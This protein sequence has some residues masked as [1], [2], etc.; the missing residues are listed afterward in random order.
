MNRGLIGSLAVLVLAT[1]CAS[2]AAARP[3]APTLPKAAE[4][5]HSP[6][7]T[8]TPAGTLVPVGQG[9]EGVVADPVTHLVAVGTR[10]PNALVLLDDRTGQVAMR[11][12][13]PGHLRHLQLAAP[14]GPVLVPDES[15]NSL[16]TVSLPTGVVQA[17]VHTGSSPHDATAA[18]NGTVFVANEAGSSVVAV[19]NKAVVHTFT[20]VVQ[21]AGL[22]AV[23]TLV[24]LVDVRQNALHIYDANTLTSRATLP[25]GAGPT[26]VEA[27]KRG[28]L[29]VIDTRGN[30]VL[31]Y[32]LTPSP[33]QL[34]R[35]AL[36]GTPYGV[37][38]DPVRD[39]LWVTLTALN[40]VVGIDVSGA[41]PRVVTTI[42]TVRQPN[43]VSVD[44]STGELFVTGTDTGVLELI[45]P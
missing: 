37:T 9:A 41:S 43:T 34:D 45:N 16:L 22:A 6:M 1:G 4:P 25:A 31:R 27:D 33:R 39:R 30:A 15:S 24:G 44:D 12:P 29:L 32:E 20:D 10:G 28:R 21:P 11:V 19:R 17:T 40:Q 14:G 7:T 35:L 42:P 36:P 38:Y 5:A 13:L 23:G 26:H 3:P 8:T 2:T 18:A